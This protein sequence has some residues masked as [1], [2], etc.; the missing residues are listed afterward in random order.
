MKK[1]II[2]SMLILTGTYL[3]LTNFNRKLDLIISYDK[4][5]LE[6][7]H[8]NEALPYAGELCMSEVMK[9]KNLN[10]V[11][12]DFNVKTSVNQNKINCYYKY[13]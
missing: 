4:S 2:I 1:Y 6:K 11:F 10:F 8:G 12:P 13:N 5:S 3:I 9:S 7:A